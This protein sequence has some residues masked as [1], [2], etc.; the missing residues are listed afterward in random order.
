MSSPDTSV[1]SPPSSWSEF[2]DQTIATFDCM[3]GTLHRL[4]PADG[5][6]KLVAH[7]G[8]PEA[9]MPV[10]QSIPVGKGIAG[11]AAQ[12]KE[13]VELCNLQTDTSGVAK[14][15]A[16]QTQVQGSLAVPVLDGGRLCGTLGIGKAVAYE[17]SAE[18]KARLTQI[19]SD[20]AA[21]LLP[22]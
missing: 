16:K 11:A 22:A 18:E 12:R 20:I 10:I 19:A 1:P 5:H 21:K 14:P 17:F 3:T 2:L 8:I 6:L 13:P 15:G 4:D 7:R 9:L